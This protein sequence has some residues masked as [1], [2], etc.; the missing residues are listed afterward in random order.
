[1]ELKDLIK[2][3]QNLADNKTVAFSGDETIGVTEGQIFWSDSKAHTLEAFPCWLKIRVTYDYSSQQSRVAFSPLPPA[4]LQKRLL[5][6]NYYPNSSLLKNIAGFRHH[7]GG[8]TASFHR[9][10]DLKFD[11]GAPLRPQIERYAVEITPGRKHDV[12]ESEGDLVIAG[13]TVFELGNPTDSYLD[14]YDCY[15]TR[16]DKLSWPEPSNV[17]PILDNGE[18]GISD[19]DALLSMIGHTGYK[20]VII[21]T[22]WIKNLEE[23]D[24][25]L[26]FATN[27]RQSKCGDR[28][29][30][31]IGKFVVTHELKHGQLTT[32]T[33]L[34]ISDSCWK[35]SAC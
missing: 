10:T 13:R 16:Y 26:N 32:K 11:L 19:R 30:G 27:W 4:P 9:Q 8:E 5:N 1:M 31:K 18:E 2:R 6:F 7:F 33:S 25:F 23:Y 20:A 29:T 12:C 17:R 22:I 3:A 15:V 34:R 21:P 14:R 28:L 35:Q 24:C